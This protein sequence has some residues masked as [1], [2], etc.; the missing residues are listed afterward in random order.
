MSLPSDVEVIAVPLLSTRAICES[1]LQSSHWVGMCWVRAN[2]AVAGKP[3][4]NRPQNRP[5]PLTMGHLWHEYHARFRLRGECGL[6]ECKRRGAS[7]GYGPLQR[8]N[9]PAARLYT[10]PK[11]GSKPLLNTCNVGWPRSQV[12]KCCKGRVKKRET[13][14]QSR[15]SFSNQTN[16]VHSGLHYVTSVACLVFVQRKF[17]RSFSSAGTEQVSSLAECMRE[18]V[19]IQH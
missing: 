8:P 10:W 15:N 1:G 6:A 12:R 19:I 9:W 2:V 13:A 4:Q 17:R 7:D 16:F 14:S 18:H 3:P 11:H 5:L